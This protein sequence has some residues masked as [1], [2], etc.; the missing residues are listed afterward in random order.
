MT[1][2]PSRPLVTAVLV[3]SAATI[4]ALGAAALGD[5]GTTGLAVRALVSLPATALLVWAALR[6]TGTPFSALGLTAPDG[7]PAA[8]TSAVAGL[9]AV[10]AGAAL[11]LGGALLLGG[12]TAP[13]MTASLWLAI[14][15]LVLA[16]VLPEEAVFRGHV[17]HALGL[18]WRGLSVA[19]GQAALFALSTAVVQG[20]ARN[21]AMPFLLGFL[22]GYLR[23]RSGA[24]WNV[25]GVRTGLVVAGIVAT[26]TDPS[27]G[28]E[29]AL[30]VVPG[31]AAVGVV[32]L[33]R[34][35]TG[36]AGGGLEPLPRHP[37]SQKGVLYDVGSSY[38]P[39]QHSR[40]RWRPDVVAEEI[41]VIAEELRCT[42]VT[43]FGHDLG[44]LEEAT[45]LALARGLFVWVQP[46]L[47]DGSQDEIVER[48]ERAAV[49]CE[50]LRAEHP[51]RVG[52]NVGCELTLFARGII[53]GRS[54][55]GR[56]VALGALYPLRPLFDGRLNRLLRR[57]VDT[58]RPRF[59]GPLT[60]GSGSWEGVD[61]SPFDMVGVDHYLDITTRGDERGGLRTLRR[62][63]KPILVTEFGCCAYEG[64]RE[65]GGSGADILD[66][67]DLD[68]R[69]VRPGYVRD[70]RV[71]ADVIEE[72]LDVYETEDV[73][74]AF[75]CMFIE[76]DCR[77]SPDPDRDLDKASFGIV[78]P[79][80]LESGLSPDDGHW[81][82]KEAFHALA[83]RYASP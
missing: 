52:L 81:E 61:W 6:V 63:G 27:P 56:T 9:A 10:L 21:L 5:D 62:W 41:R 15:L 59:S 67:R 30:A 51:D 83:R 25:L 74:G 54:F 66:W 58:A 33:L 38:L 82:P 36:A 47:V 72:L 73:H 1:D 18:R 70:E 75:V 77:Y 71:Q 57:L 43:V 35:A 65:A 44:R 4:I 64:A 76:G 31:L 55:G 14:P 13:T 50:R 26:G 2:P 78:R 29:I 12:A 53:P 20:D 49:F 17:Q 68:D 45:R 23:L 7:A 11:V 60:Y 34:P 28:W 39:G 42:A 46:R 24:L 19:A 8:L 79:P 16:V 69:K 3:T 48:L 40:E 32:H 22:L 80:S 37:L